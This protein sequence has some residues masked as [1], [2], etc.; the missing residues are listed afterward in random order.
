MG[1]ESGVVMAVVRV[2][3]LSLQ[4]QALTRSGGVWGTSASS[5]CPKQNNALKRDASGQYVQLYASFKDVELK[6][7]NNN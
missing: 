2:M 7:K 5:I 6:R 3:L 4:F 1:C